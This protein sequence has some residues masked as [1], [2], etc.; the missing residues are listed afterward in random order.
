MKILYV[1]SLGGIDLQNRT[2]WRSGIRSIS[3]LLPIQATWDTRS[4]CK[5]GFFCVRS[6][7]TLHGAAV[8]DRERLYGPTSLTSIFWDFSVRVTLP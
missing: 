7:L 3:L 2:A 4:R 5:M 6:G 8:C 1:C